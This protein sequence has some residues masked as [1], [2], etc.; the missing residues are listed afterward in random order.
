[1]LAEKVKILTKYSDFSN[2]FL[3]KKALVL[4][5]ITELNQYVI[6]LQE[7][8]ELFYRPIYS[9]NLI[10]LKKKKFTLKSIL[11]TILFGFLNPLLVHLFFLF[12]NQ[13][14]FFNYM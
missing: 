7:G 8:Q 10:K 1:M 3:E 9:L 13:M 14:V 6:K 2:V 4:L 5:E 12:A 11:S